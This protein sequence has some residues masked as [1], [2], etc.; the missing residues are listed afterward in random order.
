M[1][2]RTW[3]AALVAA[4]LLG[5]ATAP[6]RADYRAGALAYEA[7]RYEEALAEFM[8]LT[9]A[10]D[11]AA[12]FMVGVMYFYGKGVR[13]DDGLAAIWFYKAARKGN[14][15]AQLAFGSMHIRGAGVRRD[16]VTAY[17]WLT[18]AVESGVAGL[19][20]Q[21]AILR[22]DAGRLMTRRERARARALADDFEPGRAGISSLE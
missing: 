3:K 17:M 2:N 18:L 6:A 15:N 8:P 22:A 20:Q 9:A 7:G 11:P 10:G 12:E 4:L 13:R 5:L 14:A 19:R 16:L 21:A 1:E